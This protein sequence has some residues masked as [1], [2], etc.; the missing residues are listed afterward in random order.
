[1]VL[2]EEAVEAKAARE[3]ANSVI[4]LRDGLFAEQLEVWDLVEPMRVVLS[5]RR[6]G[7][8]WMAPRWLLDDAIKGET[9]LYIA[10]TRANAERNV[11]R[12]IKQ[13]VRELGIPAKFDE[14]DL[15]VEFPDT[16]GRVL[17]AGCPDRSAIERFR[18]L[19]FSRVFVDECGTFK[20]N[21]LRPLVR[22]VLRPA[23][24]D[25]EGV[26]IMAGTPGV[27]NAGY[28]Y[29]LSGPERLSTWPLR[30]WTVLDNPYLPHATTWLRS[31][32]ENNGWTEDNVTYQREYMAQWREGV[33][34]KCFPLDPELNHV[35]ELPKHTSTG[36]PLL[37]SGWSFAIG[38]DFGKVDAT[39]LAVVATHRLL[40][41]D[42]VLHVER[43]ER[44]SQDHLVARIRA[45]REKWP[46]SRL[47]GDT[48]GMGKWPV[49]EIAL[50]H[51]IT[52][53]AAEKS[54]K[55]TVCRVVSDRVRA[56]RILVLRGP[57]TDA[58]R[59]EWGAMLWDSDG[60]LPDDSYE[61][62]CSDATIYALRTLRNYRRR[63][64]QP[65]PPVGSP[66][67]FAA[68]AARIE[69]TM[70]KKWRQERGQA[71]GGLPGWDR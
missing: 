68:E 32:L 66:E 23:C 37:A 12:Q 34:G 57:Q 51:G 58:L 2:Q 24:L 3:D 16:G 26:I 46:T 11:W 19:F 30:T 31:E 36:V 56:R 42:Y 60:L 39:A 59:A 7:K 8:S 54:E 10:Q 27:H 6:A 61:D 38:I 71:R 18:G 47:I 48:G 55:A 43:W 52:I 70:M 25:R 65:S 15:T 33:A 44:V 67:Y 69:A 29:E 40:I 35:S 4:D 62:H 63:E 64:I 9:T 5:G 21:V 50:R 14:T 20:D 45:L 28:W 1:M 22:D 49:D 53:E 13:I 41:T 17:L